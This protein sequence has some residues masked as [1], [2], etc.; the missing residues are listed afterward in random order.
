MELA[1]KLGK[2]MLDGS[3]HRHHLSSLAFLVTINFG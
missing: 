1:A 2:K 3:I